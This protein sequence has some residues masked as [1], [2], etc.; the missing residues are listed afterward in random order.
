LRRSLA[1]SYR[2]A[3]RIRIGEWGVKR[4]WRVGLVVLILVFCTG[5]DQVTKN[6]ARE[7]LAP[8]P[9]ISALNDFVQFEYV[10]NLGAFLGLGSN[11]PQEVRFV[12]LV[13]LAS[14]SLVLTLA[15]IAR[16]HK[17]DLKLLIGLS[18]LAGG[19]AG[20]LIDRLINKGAVTDFMRL[21]I[22]SIQTGTFNVADVAIMAG[23]VILMLWSAGERK[24]T[25]VH[26]RLIGRR[27]S[28]LIRS[29][30]GEHKSGTGIR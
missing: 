30:E 21:G 17:S 12:L 11:L 2:E 23:V 26:L 20:N 27:K 22:G 6:M 3:L 13:V 25:G 29:K 10:E 4:M 5:C 7:W 9:P 18:F 1:F 28:V 15:L 24:G 14:A 19:G 16:V 8:S